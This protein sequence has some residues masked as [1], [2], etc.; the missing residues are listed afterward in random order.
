MSIRF[1]SGSSWRLVGS[2]RPDS[3]VG[4][5]PAGIVFS[6]WALSNPSAWGLLAPVLLENGGWA[7]FITT[8]RGRN[9]AFTMYQMA[10]KSPDWFTEILTVDHTRAISRDAVE[11][12]RAEYHG[13]Y[14]ADAGDALIE[15]EYFCSFEAAI[16][17]AYWGKELR[18]LEDE[19][20]ITSV[21]VD[22]SLP[23]HTAWDLGIGDSTALWFFQVTGRELRIVDWY[24]ASGRGL[25][26]YR[27]VK[28][29]KGYGYGHDFVPHDAKVRELGTGRTRIETMKQLDLK[30]RLVPMHKVEDGI[31]AV[32]RSLPRCWF[33]EGRCA[34]GIERLRQY[35]AA[36]DDD[37]KIFSD[38]PLHDWTSHSADAFRYL[39]MAWRE[40]AGTP[41]DPPKPKVLGVGSH[42]TVTFNDLLKL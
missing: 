17:G 40:L 14:G 35:K 10:K 8:P 3:L 22:E 18:K 32:R 23:V 13:L 19:K 33:D 31:N 11:E 42:N 36:W 34:D 21:P 37:K 5:A 28:R 26:H 30:P 6:E 20:R 12:Q 2:D 1:K 41:A 4:T 38:K 7:D 25:D 29:D 27:D 16:L 9:H 24:E 39:C 15:Q